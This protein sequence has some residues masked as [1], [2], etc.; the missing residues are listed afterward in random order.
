[1]VHRILILTRVVLSL[2]RARSV[3]K[4]SVVLGD[5]LDQ[6]IVGFASV[7]DDQE[8]LNGGVREF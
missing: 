7:G 3:P 8:H 6:L 1:M 5:V 4:H 2:F